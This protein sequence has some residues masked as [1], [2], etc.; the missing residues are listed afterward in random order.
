MSYRLACELSDKITAIAPVDG[1]IPILLPPECS[2]SKPV[3]VLAINNTDDPLVPFYGGEIWG[4]LHRLK[5]GKVLSVNE[6]IGFWV[7]RNMCSVTPVVTDEPDR[8]PDD[9]TTVTVKE[10]K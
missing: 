7:N 4:R 10:Q 3:S 6:S 1:N 2:P 8:D 9:G 5:L